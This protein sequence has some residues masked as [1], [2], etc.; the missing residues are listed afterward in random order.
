[1]NI[2]TLKQRGALQRDKVI[3]EAQLLGI[4]KT[5]KTHKGK[6]EQVLLVCA[7]ND[8]AQEI[9]FYPGK[10]PAMGS[11]DVGNSFDFHMWTKG[12]YVKCWLNCPEP[13]KRKP[14]NFQ[15]PQNKGNGGKDG[16]IERQ[17]A[18]RHADA[19]LQAG[20]VK[21][22]EEYQD[23]ACMCKRY[24]STG[25]WGQWAFGGQ[26]V[27]ETYEQARA[28]VQPDWGQWAFGGQGVDETYEQA[29]ADVQPEEGI[30]F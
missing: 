24:I 4:Q 22:R 19:A 11:G 6:P 1:M 16:S 27:D 7:E 29:R 12:E 15:P 26:G 14:A 10:H 20:L 23:H 21:T 5:G 18:L 8:D 30:P 25:D 9:D 13:V 2:T 28:D 3:I 17:N